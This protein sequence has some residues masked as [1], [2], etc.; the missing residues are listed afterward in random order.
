M[1]SQVS[2]QQ[3]FVVN[4]GGATIDVPIY[5]QG[6]TNYS[7]NIVADT[8]TYFIGDGSQ[9]TNLPNQNNNNVITGT[10]S[11]NQQYELDTWSATD[12]S[13][14]K[15]YIEL[16]GSYPAIS[17]AT[18]IHIEE[19]ILATSN[20]GVGWDLYVTRYGIIWS[21]TAL[22]VFAYD[23]VDGNVRLLFSPNYYGGSNTTTYK[24]IKTMA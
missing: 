2:F 24:I 14:A 13:S 18:Q 23:V 10:I 8:G 7:G 4:G 21:W 17:Q 5:S 9:L 16:T 1:D 6:I 3:G 19:I 20:L 22:G 12:H 11:E 15:Y